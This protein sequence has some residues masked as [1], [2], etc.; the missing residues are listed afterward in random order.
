MSNLIYTTIFTNIQ[1]NTF[2]INKK[3][4][5]NTITSQNKTIIVIQYNKINHEIIIINITQHH[6]IQVIKN[7][8]QKITN[9]IKCYINNLN[10][11]IHNLH[12]TNK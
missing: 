2:N 1:F 12:K 3:L 6:K 10:H 9:H 8:T 7:N 4:I 5:K 11:I